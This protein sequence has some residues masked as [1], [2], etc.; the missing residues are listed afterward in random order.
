MTMTRLLTA[1]ALVALLAGP[2]AA[3]VSP[4]TPS[5]GQPADAEGETPAT[6]DTTTQPATATPPTAPGDRTM[7][8]TGQS[9]SMQPQGSMGQGST[10][11]GGTMGATASG[12]MNAG[13]AQ[14]MQASGNMNAGGAMAEGV[15]TTMNGNV[16]VVSN[17]PIP[18]T[19]ENR[20]R[21]GQPESGA[22]KSRV[23]EGPVSSLPSRAK[24]RARAGVR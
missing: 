14:G 20:A 24:A 4:N 12:N 7:G 13:G 18:D 3:Q 17:A 5:S 22:G 6:N 16:R 2:V 8:Q 23:G 15:I 1:T 10:N 19:V 9:G 11:A 21:Y